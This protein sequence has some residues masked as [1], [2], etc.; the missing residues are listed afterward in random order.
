MLIFFEKKRKMFVEYWLGNSNECLIFARSYSMDKT[1]NEQL[2]TNAINSITNIKLLSM[3][4]LLTFFVAM[5]ASISLMAQVTTSSISG[6]IT[7]NNKVSLQGATVVATHTPSGSQYYAVA[8]ANGT[9]RLLN[10]RPGG[11]YTIEVRM[12]GFQTVK[13]EG[14]TA[15][16][17]ET[18]IINVRLNEEAIG[19]GEVSVVAEAVSNGM[20]S[21]RAG[22]T[23]TINMEK[24]STLPTVTRNLNDVL[25]L[26]PQA[27]SNTSGLAIGGGNYRGSYV[28]VDG[29]AFNNAFGIGQNLPANG[30]PISLDALEAMTINITPFDVRQSGFTG[31]A[32]NAVTKSGTN[33]WHAT[34][35][36]FFTNNDFKGYK[37][38]DNEVNNTYSL[39][40]TTGFS[41]GGPIVKDKLFFFVNGE[42]SLDDVAGS[43]NI[44]RTDASQE[45]GNSVAY[46]RPLESQM[47]EIKSFL[48]N[49]FNYDPGRYQNYS[50]STP[51]YKALARLDWN[52]NEKNSL[53]LRFSY[54]HNYGSNSPS[55]SM[56]PLSGNDV[57]YT[58]N[59]IDYQ[60]NRN[61]GGRQSAFA[62]PFESARYFQEQNFMTAA[63]ELNTRVSSR[64][65]NMFRITWS[66]QYEPRSYVGS[67]FPTVDIMSDDNSGQG[68][69]GTDNTA[70]LTTFGV[71]PFTYG[72]L[73]D[74][75]T[76]VG[77]DEFSWS[78]GMHSFT[79]GLQ[80]EWNRTKNGFMQGGAGWYLYNSWEDFVNDVNDP[81]NAAGP[82]L[83]MITH[84]NN[85]T[86]TQEFPSFDYHQMSA[87][88]QDEMSLSEYF[89][90]TAGLRFE[91][92][93]L[94]NPNNNYNADFDAVA[95]ANPNSSFAGLSTADLPNNSI[96]IANFSPRLGFNWD[97]LKDRSLILRG[98]T[99][100]F[101]GRI[102]FV[103]I[104]SAMGN[105]NVLQYQY[106]ANPSTGAAPIHFHNTIDDQL[107]E[108]YA[109]NA[110][111]QQELAAP[112]SATIIAKDLKMPSAWK[113]SLGLD[114]TLPGGIKGTVEGIYSY[115]FNEVYATTLGIKKDGEIQLP[116]EPGAR[117]TWI[118]EGIKNKSNGKMN[119]Y[120]LK[121]E[122]NLHGY[123][124]SVT[125]QLLKEFNNGLSLMGAYTYSNAKSL[126]DGAG[127]QISEFGTINNVNGAN[128]P[129][130]G[131]A[132]YVAPH[133]VLANISYNI[134]EGK[135]LAT[136][137]GLFY[138]GFNIGFMGYYSYSRVSYLMNDVS[139][140]GASQLIYIPTKD[141]LQNMPFADV[142][143][144]D[145]KLIQ[146]AAENR[147]AYEN[148][149]S[150]DKYLSTHRGQYEQRNA[151]LAPWL[152]RIN[153]HLGQEFKFDILGKTNSIEVAADVK[154]ILN[155][156]NSKWSNYNALSS[157]VI[158]NYDKNSQTYTFTEPTWEPYGNTA[159]T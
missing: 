85:N 140:T 19:I 13:Q 32:I 93:F 134:K 56:K 97:I 20:D 15:T 112:T 45:F 95:Q 98:G 70:I 107:N 150:G 104:V 11:P 120:Y 29:A 127:D 51:D 50:L 139:G 84:P 58:V 119:G 62:M 36:D 94:N 6:K 5:I 80:Y 114:A 31:S 133:R 21:D 101:T 71:D 155:L 61:S 7:D 100:L 144:K 83:Y 16:L 74:V 116:G 8:D 24:V 102:P 43:T 48:I 65:N 18:K 25:S 17:G 63:A 105:S 86:L 34:V 90:L 59:G 67:F 141:Q 79:S 53:A 158:L 37:V 103:W 126:S 89:K 12:V 113:S 153:F 4:K 149:I 81:A 132:N 129:E 115:N 123:Y 35:Y 23:T 47:D 27:A 46:N 121:N 42:Y 64:A 124:Y 77:T 143:D 154:N 148:F 66:H 91:M 99:G 33:D 142:L 122:S 41:V 26:T 10:I 137:I 125:A 145:G 159:S 151:I 60:F 87:Y 109:G 49:K 146:T 52:I 14:V 68:F 108:L 78:N 38:Y 88:F 131:Y 3:K 96:S 135:N 57:K 111:T 2:K 30:S 75:Q 1:E 82:A 92:P 22:A 130:L 72:N 128:T 73:R 9:Y 55:S 117:E 138:E 157:N 44:A 28:T 39:S 152:N 76:V 147:A 54:T 40:N 69:A 118:S 156:I 136:N 110:F 106:I